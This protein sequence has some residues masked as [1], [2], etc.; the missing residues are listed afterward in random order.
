MGR[1]ESSSG[2]RRSEEHAKESQREREKN[3]PQLSQTHAN[4]DEGATVACLSARLGLR[5]LYV[6]C[7][8]I[9]T[10]YATQSVSSGVK[11]G[12]KT[13]EWVSP[14]AMS[15]VKRSVFKEKAGCE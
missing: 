7:E 4:E 10:M 11:V 1:Q 9:E 15:Y 3:G 12:G 13:S 2:G 6:E 5:Y 14:A 8:S